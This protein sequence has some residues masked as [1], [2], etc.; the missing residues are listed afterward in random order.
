MRAIYFNKRDPETSA[1]REFIKRQKHQLRLDLDE[2]V[3]H[4]GE[5]SIAAAEATKIY[6]EQ[7]AFIE[8][9][10]DWVDAS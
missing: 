3:F 7:M 10:L 8:K 9:V 2:L 1:L 4:F 5:D 6:A